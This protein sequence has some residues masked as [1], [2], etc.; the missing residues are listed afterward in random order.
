MDVYGDNDN[1]F[2]AYIF[3]SQ[4]NHLLL[5]RGAMIYY[6]QTKG[7]S[8]QFFEYHSQSKSQNFPYDDLRS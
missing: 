5:H 4:K 1:I 2:Q 7:Q 3:P 8:P 6:D